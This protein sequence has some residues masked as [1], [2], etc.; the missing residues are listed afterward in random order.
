MRRRH[1]LNLS[2]VTVLMV[3]SSRRRIRL[4]GC[5]ALVALVILP[6]INSGLAVQADASRWVTIAPMPTQ[7][8]SLAAALG[9]DGRIYALGGN[10]LDGVSSAVEAYDPRR[11]AWMKDTPLPSP[12]ADLAAVSA[13]DGRIYPVLVPSHGK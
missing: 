11:D 9:S 8:D 4:R 3:L 2:R 10:A 1:I 6:A 5:L 7:R 13:R 12:R